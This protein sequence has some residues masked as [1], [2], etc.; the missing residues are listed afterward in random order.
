MK[1]LTDSL[2]EGKEWAAFFVGVAV[3]VVTAAGFA[4]VQTAPGWATL[5]V[6]AIV[7]GVTSLLVYR[8]GR[9]DM[10][11]DWRTRRLLGLLGQYVTDRK[12]ATAN[13]LRQQSRL[14]DTLALLSKHLP[15]A[16]PPATEQFSEVMSGDASAHWW[17]WN[18]VEGHWLQVI[19]RTGMGAKSGPVQ[20]LGAPSE[21]KVGR[22]D[23]EAVLQVMAQFGTAG[24][25]V[26]DMRRVSWADANDRA[27]VLTTLRRNPGPS[28]PRS[29]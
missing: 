9:L 17:V 6:M 1:G 24:F 19:E 3:V 22:F 10:L 23:A 7:G 5:A 12:E 11:V 25:A 2:V 8:A 4:P 13:N 20:V 27:R 15:G 29:N 21:A 16:V 18:V 28:D 14:A 26:F